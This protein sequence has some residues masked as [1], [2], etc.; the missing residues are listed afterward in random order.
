MRF[1]LSSLLTA[2]IAVAPGMARGAPEAKGHPLLLKA[3]STADVPK[4]VL[5]ADAPPPESREPAL[6]MRSILTGVGAVAGVVAFNAAALGAGAFPG[7][8]AYAAGATVPA[9]M[10]VAI[11]RL[12][13]VVSAVAGGS[14]GEYLYGSQAQAPTT[15]GRVLSAA[16]GAIASVSAFGLLTT[17]L[18]AAP[19]A[20]ATLEAIPVSTMVGSRLIA[21]TTAGL[22]ALAANFAYD[23][24]TGERMDPVYALSLFAGALIGVAAGN[25][26]LAGELGAPPYYVG[27]G[28]ASAGGELATVM[29]SAASRAVAVTTGVVGALAAHWLSSPDVPLD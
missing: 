5:V 11:N 23:Q 15:D 27:A 9:E 28:A 26:L 20:G 12:Y 1:I 16:V 10:A 13:A 25:L 24:S 29:M 8:W 19:F 21:V 7:G 17:P 14:L 6:G 18:G 2:S 22:G 4:R 3:L